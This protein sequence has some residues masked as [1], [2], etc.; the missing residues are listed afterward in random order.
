MAKDFKGYILLI[1]FLFFQTLNAVA[2]P[3]GKALFQANCAACHNPYKDATGPA[4]NGVD[5]RV[6]SKEWLY[7]WIKNS[8]S[9]I[10][11]GDKYANDI[12]NKWNKTAMT[13]FPSLTNEEMDAIITYVNLPPPAPKVAPNPQGDP[14][15][16]SSDNTLLYAILTII[17]LVVVIV[18]T[19]VNK[20]LSRSANAREGVPSP[21]DVPFFRNKVVI[22]LIAIIII[23]GFGIWLTKGSE[24]GRQKNYMPKQPIFYSHKVHAGINQINCLYCHAGAEKS[25]HAMIPSSNVCMNC[26]KQI[27]EYTGVDQHPLVDL[28]GN[29]VDG[30]KEIQKLYEYAGWDP[31]KKDY[32]RDT[33]GTI[34]AKPIEWVKIHNLPD[35]VYFNH[36]LHVVSGKLAC[37]RCHG[38]IEEMDEVYQFADL[39][40]G[41]CV[42]CH[43]NT[44]VQFA[45]NNYYSIFQK[46]HD[47]I[48]EGKRADVKVSDIGGLECQKCHY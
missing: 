41:W 31:V 14:N 36:S 20:V 38:N 9:L 39:S 19:S 2:A 12:Y 42:N 44:S 43:R 37:Q 47:E 23:V 29:K 35:H 27:N 7:K 1:V 18:L 13:A 30:N 26:H 21:K 25:R 24:L 16:Q 4:L 34:L 33:T 8:A 40:M 6:P 28:E 22:A 5:S 48:K 17:L 10:G 46:Y 32:K 3:D 45:D 11:S 15:A